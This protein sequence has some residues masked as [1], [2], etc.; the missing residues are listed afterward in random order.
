MSET[1]VAEP[2]TRLQNFLD[3]AG[4]R[5]FPWKTATILYT[6]S[7]GWLFIVRDSLWADDWILMKPYDFSIHGYAPWV[8]VQMK[9]M[10]SFGLTFFRS[11]VYIS[12]LMAAVFLFG[13]T[14]QISFLSL[15][16][17]RLVVLLFLLLPFNTARVALMVYWNNTGYLVFFLAWYL[18]VTF[19][20]RRMHFLSIGLFFISFQLHSLLPFYLL[21]VLHLLFLSDIRN[22][23]GLVLFLRMNLFFFF[24]LTYWVFRS[25]F[26]PGNNYH[27]VSASRAASAFPF[28]L[29]ALILLGL[30]GILQTKVRI[31]YK[32]AVK[33][34]LSGFV[35]VFA[36]LLAYVVLG[37]FKSDWSFF[38]SY[39]ITLFGRSDWYSRHQIL[40]PLGVALLIV[41]A[42][43]LLPKRTKKLSMQI[44]IAVLSFCVVFNVGFGFE[45]VVD[46]SRQKAVISELKRV[47]DDKAKSTTQF[48]DQTTFLNARGHLY[49]P[50]DWS[51]LIWRAYGFEARQRSNIENSCKTVTNARLVLIQGPE[52]HW[53]A[54]K[55]WVSDGDMGFKVTVDD[56]PG[57]CKPEMVTAEKVSGAIPILFYFTGAK[58]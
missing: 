28:V 58:G 43:A 54:L 41:G 5:G 27:V 31:E 17:R 53:Q 42:I 32:N 18:A 37:F 10:R 29:V 48:V 12:F 2:G 9:L 30:L 4:L 39:F 56:T 23:R 55:N 36:G 11:T 14:R 45:Y 49:R 57:A 20:S 15:S 22:L 3:R 1:A 35:A 16:Q 47:G 26:W 40:Q 7:W 34:L 8:D 50:W 13:I 21:P 24:P 44:Q 33:I 25:L 46:Y 52:T 38:N 51:G 6:I 19:R